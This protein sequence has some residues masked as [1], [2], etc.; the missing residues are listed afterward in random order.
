[1]NGDAPNSA[2]LPE[3]FPQTEKAPEGRLVAIVVDQKNIRP[4]GSGWMAM[5]AGEFVDRLKP[6]DRVAVF[7]LG[8]RGVRGEFTRDR[9]RIKQAL[10]A[11]VG[12]QPEL[13]R[14]TTVERQ[15]SPAEAVSITGGDMAALDRITAR[16]CRTATLRG[17]PGLTMLACREQIIVE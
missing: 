14:M 9:L 1:T 6:V 4:E 2:I 10:A 12:Q 11:A 15:V 3:G 16:E 7:G 13:I 5:A 17:I 8:E